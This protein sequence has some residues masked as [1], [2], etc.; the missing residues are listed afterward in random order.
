MS[1]PSAADV[2]ATFNR[3]IALAKQT[4]ADHPAHK[5][6]ITDSLG[7]AQNL[8]KAGSLG[9][10]QKALTQAAAL[11]DAVAKEGQ[12]AGNSAMANWQ[13]ARNRV[14]AS[15]RELEGKIR[16]MADP[17]SDG[18]IILVKSIQANLA[19]NPATPQ[20]MAELEQYLKTDSVIT[21]AEAPNGFG[22]KIDIRSPLLDA[23]G[24]LKPQPRA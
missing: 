4:V 15:L 11:L 8:I 18:A 1:G 23:L 2:T 20:Q 19:G 14:V 9:E 5:T 7:A 21:D 13:S 17:E 10:A 3:L 16:A 6:R 24:K 22:I 12:G